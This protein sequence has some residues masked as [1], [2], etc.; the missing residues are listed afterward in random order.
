MKRL[1]S[2]SSLATRKKDLILLGLTLSVVVL[3]FSSIKVLANQPAY[4]TP[5]PTNTTID[6]D[7]TK[8]TDQTFASS[9][10]SKPATDFSDPIENTN[11]PTNQNLSPQV[12]RSDQG[13]TTP[14]PQPTL[15]PEVT[16]LSQ[17][18]P[19]PTIIPTTLAVKL[20]INL[21]PVI[22]L[23]VTDQINQCDLL[24]QAFTQGKLTELNIRYFSE[25][26]SLGVLS[27]NGIG[28][29]NQVYWTYKVNG[30]SPPLGCSQVLVKSGDFVFWEYQSN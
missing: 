23:S 2:K 8:I 3:T 10:D 17:P 21:D 5:E 25:Y 11:P 4:L 22:Q 12:T 15:T 20:Q 13:P 30:V 19:Q 16:S 28:N 7:S 24:N 29:P 9:P 6:Q 27:I 18:T 1:I 26:S 14:N